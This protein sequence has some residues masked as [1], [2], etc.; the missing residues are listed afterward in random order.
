MYPA[1][2]FLSLIFLFIQILLELKLKLC[3]CNQIATERGNDVSFTTLRSDNV[4]VH[5]IGIL[6]ENGMGISDLLFLLWPTKGR[7]G[8]QAYRR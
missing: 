5:F 8:V 3:Y 7:F 2:F 4:A 6:S 1:L